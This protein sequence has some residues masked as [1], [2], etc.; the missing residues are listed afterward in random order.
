MP[1]PRKRF[2]QHWLKSEAILQQIIEAADLDPSDRVLEIG[3]G[4]GVL[5]RRLLPAVAALVAVEIDRDLCRKLVQQLGKIDNFLLLE[6]DFLG[7]DLA[8]ALIPFSRFQSPRKVVANIP[9]NITAP[10]LKSLLGTIAHPHTAYERIVLLVQKEVGD[11]L[12][13]LPRSKAYGALSVRIQ[14]L[15]Q[16][17]V[18]CP[19]PASAF[20]PPPAVESAVVR[21]IPRLYPQPARNPQFLD[22]LIKLGFANRRK[23]LRNNLKSLGEVDRLTPLLEQLEIDPQ[24]RAEDLSLSQ[25]IALSNR[26]VSPC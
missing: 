6:A 18:I 9:Y 15:A 2:G 7:L 14:Y 12:T 23:M 11:R 17:E 5:T 8:R 21:L 24:T 3:P 20:L 16:T 19:V 1:R 13:A 10:I 4:Q 26:L 22:R 25:W